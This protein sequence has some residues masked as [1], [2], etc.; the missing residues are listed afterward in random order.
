MEYIVNDGCLSFNLTNK[1][2]GKIMFVLKSQ[3]T[4]HIN[5]ITVS[6]KYRGNNYSTEMFNLFYDHITQKYECVDSITLLT[7]EIYEKYKKLERLYSS[8][9]FITE[10]V[11]QIYYDGDVCCRKIKMVKSVKL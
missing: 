10:G 2:I 3:T 9:G 7:Q 11:E 5:Y 4:I 8:W 6:K 1:Y